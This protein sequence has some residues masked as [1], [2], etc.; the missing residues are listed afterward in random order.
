[1]LTQ[2]KLKKLYT[3]DEGSGAFLIRKPYGKAQKR[4]GLG[5]VREDGYIAIGL[6][7]KVYL[8]HRLVWLYV[9]G[10]L[11]EFIDHIDHIR[12]NN[13]LVNLRE[14]TRTENQQNMSKRKDN[15]SGVCGVSW[16]KSRKRWTARIKVDG[17]YLFLGKFAEFHEAVNARK[18]SE[19]LYGY[20]SNHGTV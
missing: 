3:Y 19:I 2:K 9:Y 11:P 17:K 7:G 15:I 16:D 12:N 14:V 20:H 6:E 5:Y 1:M 8:A 18:N 4:S 10:Y 13:S